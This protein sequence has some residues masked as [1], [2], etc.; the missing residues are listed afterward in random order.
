V[1]E[2]LINVVIQGESGY[3]VMPSG[4]PVPDHLPALLEDFL[5]QSVSFFLRDGKS[6]PYSHAD[7]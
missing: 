2:R 4:L 6:T 7:E 1:K 5:V 3:W